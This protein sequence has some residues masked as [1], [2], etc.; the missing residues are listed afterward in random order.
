LLAIPF[1]AGQ[2]RHHRGRADQK[3][4]WHYHQAS[5]QILFAITVEEN[6]LIKVCLGNYIIRLLLRLLKIRVVEY[7]LKF[8]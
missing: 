1:L 4:F 3:A 2:A 8:I 7:I 6:E 5:T